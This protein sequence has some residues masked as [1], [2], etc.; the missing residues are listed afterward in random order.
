MSPTEN[1][2]HIQP[3][4]VIAPRFAFRSVPLTDACFGIAGLLFI[5][6]WAGVAAMLAASG[7]IGGIVGTFTNISVIPVVEWYV[8][9]G[10]IR[11]LKGPDVPVPLAFAPLV[12]FV[13]ASALVHHQRTAFVLEALLLFALWIRTPGLGRVSLIVLLIALQLDEGLKP[14]HGLFSTVD[15]HVLPTV[16]AAIGQPVVR[17]GNLIR[18]PGLPD[19]LV[20]LAGCASTKLMLPMGLGFIALML[21]SHERLTPNDWRWLGLVL[22]AAVVMNLVRL[23]LMLQS[24]AAFESW[25]VG[26]GA[27]IVSVAGLIVTLSAW[28]A[29][30]GRDGTK[31][32]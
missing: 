8:L 18:S 26:N 15:A 27:S 24:H 13:L 5:Q 25:H 22:A 2:A 6:Y 31:P 32:Q 20:L 16:M 23:C 21:G 3:A 14:L 17:I 28:F 1:D 30:T 12:V 4:A 10:M 19:G 9:F 7:G 29:A 11:G